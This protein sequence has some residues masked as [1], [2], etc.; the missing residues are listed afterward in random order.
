VYEYNIA[1]TL[2]CPSY[3]TTKVSI[4]ALTGDE[5]TQKSMDNIVN[6]IKPDRFGKLITKAIAKKSKKFILLEQKKN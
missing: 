6:G 1:V 4:N 2:T 3:V 5:S